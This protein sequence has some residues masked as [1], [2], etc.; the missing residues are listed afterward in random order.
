[1]TNPALM[2]LFGCPTHRRHSRVAK[3]SLGTFTTIAYILNLHSHLGSYNVF[4]YQFSSYYEQYMYIC[5]K[6]YAQFCTVFAQ[7]TSKM[8]FC[9]SYY[10]PVD[11]KTIQVI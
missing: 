4:R 8:Y 11:N 9:I 3:I 2:M 5:T 7:I 1:M 6:C 10:L